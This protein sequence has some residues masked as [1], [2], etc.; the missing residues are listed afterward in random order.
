VLRAD[1]IEQTRH[2][3]DGLTIV[4]HREVKQKLQVSSA[5]L[6]AMIARGLFPKPFRIIPNGRAV[7]WLA[8]DVD[9]WILKQRGEFVEG[10]R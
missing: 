5:T 4:R 3:H 2:N 10:T 9:E 7:G 1:D 6:F 8:S